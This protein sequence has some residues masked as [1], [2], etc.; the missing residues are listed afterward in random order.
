[1]LNPSCL[2]AV[3]DHT[4]SLTSLPNHWLLGWDIQVF[5]SD[6]E[7]YLQC[8]TME[9]EP[10][11]QVQRCNEVSKQ[12]IRGVPVRLGLTVSFEQWPHLLSYITGSPK[13]VTQ[14][15]TFLLSLFCCLLFKKIFRLVALLGIMPNHDTQRKKKD[16][17]FLK[18]WKLSPEP[19]K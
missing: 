1:M 10:R 18:E 4:T 2:W 9:N 15:P 6:L 14:G 17:L 13:R 3:A 11:S 5:Y 16:H 7:K 8:R 19:P 12:E